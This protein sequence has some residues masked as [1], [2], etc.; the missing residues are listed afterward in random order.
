MLIS[1]NSL[2][3]DTRYML[4]TYIPGDCSKDVPA[5]DSNF[6]DPGSVPMKYINFSFLPNLHYK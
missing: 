6:K 2:Q 3:C 4:N 5:L 1:M